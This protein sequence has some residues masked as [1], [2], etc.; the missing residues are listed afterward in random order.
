M[1]SELRKALALE[2]I[3]WTGDLLDDCTAI[4]AGLM[5]RAEWMDEDQWWWAVYDMMRNEITIDYSNEYKE[6]FFSGEAA[7]EKAES[8]AKAYIINTTHQP[9][10]KYII[11]DTFKITGRGLVLAG[12]ITDGL[13]STGD[14][15]EIVAFETI[16]YRKIISIESVVKPHSGR[17]N[18]GLLIECKD[19]SEIDEL[20]NWVPNDIVAFIIKTE[21]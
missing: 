9:T 8:V 3:V 17:I 11:A 12:Y 7:R 14:Q 18:T 4:W 15:I 1:N 20:R 13:V 5:L 19:D 10:A 6:N 2:T 21:N 16:R